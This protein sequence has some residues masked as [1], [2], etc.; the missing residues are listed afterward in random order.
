M[1]RIISIFLT[2]MLMISTIGCRSKEDDPIEKKDTKVAYQAD[3]IEKP[4]DISK[5]QFLVYLEDGTLRIGGSDQSG[6][7]RTVWDSKNN[8]KDWILAGDSEQL[9]ELKNQNAFYKYSSDGKFYVVEDQTI[10]LYEDTQP[11]TINIVEGES[12]L[13]SALCG[14]DFY[15]LVED[16][17]GTKQIRKYDLSEQIWENMENEELVQALKKT[18]GYGC[19]AADPLAETLYT[20]DA[21]I[22][23]Y[24]VEKDETTHAINEEV[25][26]G[27]IDTINE[28]I[29]GLAVQ[30]ENIVVC[31]AGKSGS[32]SNLYFLQKEQTKKNEKRLCPVNGRLRE[33]RG[34]GMPGPCRQSKLRR[35]KISKDPIRVTTRTQ[36]GGMMAKTE[37]ERRQTMRKLVLLLTAALALT[38]CTAAPEVSSPAEAAPP[39][40]TAA[41][42]EA[43][44]AFPVG[45]LQMAIPEVMY[46]GAASVE[47]PFS[48]L[49]TEP[50]LKLDYAAGVQTKLCDIDLS[51]QFPVAIMQHGDTVEYFWDSEGST[52]FAHT[53]IR[54]DGS[55]E[56]Q[57]IPEKFY[58][59]FYDEYA[60]Y[61]IWGTTCKRLDWQT[62]ELTTA[63]LPFVQL[64]GVPGAVG[65]RVL[66]TRIVSDMP[67][68]E[69]EGNEEMRDAVLQNSLR[70]YDLYDPATNTIEKVFDEPYYPEDDNES[71]SYLGYCGDK[72]YFG[73]SC[74]DGA[75]VAGSKA[76]HRNHSKNH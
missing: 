13:D 4:K 7:K 31:T 67:L 14:Q 68:P 63:S 54:P 3:K 24:C 66:L 52:V 18:T 71:K 42:G 8:G 57:T 61:D 69:G 74:T 19:L 6:E 62:G 20:E 34:P 21:G 75:S 1:K 43:A 45:T 5:I 55:V 28:P 40:E 49:E 72:L 51:R 17:T 25:L 27:C 26:N 65:S 16:E 58:P 35:K 36:P 59:N 46:T 11:S 50:I 15:L 37:P 53:A 12:Y 47:I 64:D 70:E 73:V 44:A 39:A 38:A 56:E 60:A 30:G 41:I 2:M 22:V 33:A 10:R 32:E 29:T 48:G 23:K 76:C 9:P